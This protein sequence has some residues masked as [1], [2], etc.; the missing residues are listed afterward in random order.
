[1]NLYWT[2]PYE[3][4]FS[5]EITHNT[6]EGIIL[7]VSL[8]FPQGGGQSSDKGTIIHEGKQ[9]E[10]SH[11]S[12]TEDGI[13]HH[14][15]ED[16]SQLLPGVNVEAHINWH[17]RYELMKAHT[18]QHLLSSVLSKQLDC[19]TGSVRIDPGDVTLNLDKSITMKELINVLEE[20]N[21]LSTY[22]GLDVNQDIINRETALKMA[23]ELRDNFV[24]EEDEVRIVIIE[25]RDQICCGGTHV[26]HTSEIGP[27]FIYSF[28][29]TEIKYHVGKKAIEQ[30]NEANIN[31]LKLSELLNCSID[32][33]HSLTMKKL[34]Q[35][36]QLQ[37]E[38]DSI[39]QNLLK[40]ILIQPKF[41]KAN[42]SIFECKYNIDKD[43][44]NK[45]FDDFPENSILVLNPTNPRILILSNS[46]T[47][48]AQSLIRQM[49][50]KYGGKG[51]G[52]PRFA[53]GVI[54]NKPDEL[55]KAITDLI[56]E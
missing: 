33:V 7:N 24:P 8:F 29:G 41:Q 56:E 36:D 51:G 16:H 37:E 48:S 54:D 52:S 49:I 31:M 17:N 3:T 13:L 32:N 53:Q 47:I 15:K 18:S 27:L 44:L 23:D 1:M 20:T 26:K 10:V 2:S 6:L 5:A 50:D 30:F 25:S 14:I 34:D 45:G 55:I 28:N 11:V 12:K 21:R 42:Y 22:Q 19:N 40:L 46:E 39:K 35:A 43:I 9:Y 38:N 4:K